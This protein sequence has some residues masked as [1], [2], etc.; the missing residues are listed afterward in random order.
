MISLEKYYR[1]F[2]IGIQNAMEYRANFLISIFS[3][4]VPIFIQTFF[5]LSIYRSSEHSVIF[6]YTFSQILNYT[7]LAQ[8]VS[9]YVRTGFEYEINEDIKNGGLNKFIIR[10]IGYFTYKFFCFIGSKTV[11]FLIISIL[12]TV[13]IF[14]LTVNV[15]TSITLLSITY[16]VYSLIL[17]LSLN[18]LIFFCISTLCFWL[19]EI[20]FLFEAV[21]IIIIT[22]SGGI[23][24][25]D[26]FGLKIVRV[27]SCMPFKYTISF[28]VELLNN[29]IT[30][31]QV[32]QGFSI[33]ILWIIFFLILSVI[34]WKIGTK[35]YTAVGG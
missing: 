23:F 22:L 19:S 13:S 8:L 6:G 28:P 11:N 9:R 14:L 4:I 26:I 33:Q 20:G 5:W 17:A 2:L 15:G 35:K 29:K 10:P 25:L 31:F 3:A 27:L 1:S 32:L 12:I 18:F 30:G 16:F 21:R 34:L 24:P 7:I